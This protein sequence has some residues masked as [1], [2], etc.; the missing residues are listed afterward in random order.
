[1]SGL[2]FQIIGGNLMALWHLFLILIIFSALFQILG[3]FAVAPTRI[4]FSLFSF[5]GKIQPIEPIE[6]IEP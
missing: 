1:M 2:D 3:I 6:P 5:D 4:R